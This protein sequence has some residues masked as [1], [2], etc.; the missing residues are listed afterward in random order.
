[1]ATTTLIAAIGLALGLGSGVAPAIAQDRL[2]EWR[3]Q[4]SI[5]LTN[6]QFERQSTMRVVR[7]SGDVPN[8]MNDQGSALGWGKAAVE[9]RVEPREE[10]TDPGATIEVLRRTE[11]REAVDE[12]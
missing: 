12:K 11:A 2:D 7:S 8:T 5:E 9:G 1:M 10:L 6:P 4:P 3:G